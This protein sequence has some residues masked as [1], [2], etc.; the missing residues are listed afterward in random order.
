MLSDAWKA[1][2][3]DTLRNCFRHAG[4]AIR[5]EVPSSSDDS[6]SEAHQ[7]SSSAD[8]I[9]H[10]RAAGAVPMGVTLEQFA[11]ADS[12]IELC[13]ELTD[14][15]I[16]R[17]VLDTDDSGSDSEEPETVLP[18]SS[19]LTR[20]LMVLSAVYSENVT[21][22]DVQADLYGNVAPRRGKLTSFSSRSLNKVTFFA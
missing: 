16:V 20:A 2:T 14:D 3:E 9:E 12:E 17:Q 22:A 15:E 4:F 10:L 7:P 21:L 11:N 13:A 8:L 6:A 19:E 5:D 18:T 1:V